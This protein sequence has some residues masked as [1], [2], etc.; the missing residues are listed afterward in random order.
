MKKI[1]DELV[2]LKNV[3]KLIAS[4]FGDKC[5]AVLHDWSK[6]YDKSI[7]AIENGH[8][9]GRKIGDCGS[10]LGLEVMRGTVEDGDRFNYVTQ[11]KYGKTIRSSTIYIK[12][13]KNEVI[14]ALCLNYDIS[15][16]ISVKSFVDTMTVG[17][18]KE[19]EFFAH[20]VNELV[21]FLLKE[22]LNIVG[23]P[24]ESMTKEDKM[25]AIRYLDKKGAFLITKAGNKV[26]HF[27][28]IS[29]FTLYNYLD[30]IR[31]NNADNAFTS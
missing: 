13:D 28:D 8:I 27:F 25:E 24:V 18:Q 30:E 15:D 31:N 11:T 6:G 22:S 23:K 21:D 17:T 4:H 20:D 5:E 16:L 14:G 9:T 7:I 2:F 1:G 3:M 19:S 10:N 12:D 26:C 29:K